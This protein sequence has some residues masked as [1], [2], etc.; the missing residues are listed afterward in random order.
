M[1]D[2]SNEILDLSKSDDPKYRAVE[3]TAQNKLLNNKLF[4][5]TLLN[6]VKWAVFS[7][8]FVF[9]YIMFHLRSFFMAF[10]SMLLILFS[11]PI[12]YLLYTGLL[13]ITMN[14]TLN[15]MTI[16]IVLGIAADDI[17]VFCD[18]WRHSANI[19]LLQGGTDLHKRMAYSWRRSFGAILV[20]S[21][22]TAIA[23]LANAGSEIRPIRAFGIF[24]AIII[25]VNFCIVII[26]MPAAQIIHDRYLLPCGFC[27]HKLCCKC[28]S[29]KKRREELQRLEE[30]ARI[31]LNED[32]KEADSGKKNHVVE[33]LAA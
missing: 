28:Q 2:F 20:T 23:F 29:S 5:E 8:I 12:T 18:A 30:S 13:R 17:F 10:V 1:I 32:S 33:N 7:V 19:A 27:F 14:T 22:T 24:A 26:V 3:R 6:D 9:C 21:S 25:P 31:N 15:Q 4:R 11:F 16:F